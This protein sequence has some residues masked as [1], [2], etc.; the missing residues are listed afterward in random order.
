[1]T[2]DDTGPV[3]VQQQSLVAE[4]KIRCLLR[5]R[6]VPVGLGRKVVR[7]F[8]AA[9]PMWIIAAATAALALT[10]CATV[11]S[12]PTGREVRL[13]EAKG[14]V[15]AAI[16]T[17]TVGSDTDAITLPTSPPTTI[18]LRDTTDPGLACHER[19]HREQVIGLGQYEFIR[20]YFAETLRA[21]YWNNLFEVEAREAQA[22]CD[23]KGAAE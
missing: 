5:G 19:K 7:F 6:P 3:D 13:E 12:T 2:P 10:S 11:T 23:E 15:V 21:G 14:G 9:W 1:M 17:N 4:E 22:V 18:M 8:R 16:M 20:R